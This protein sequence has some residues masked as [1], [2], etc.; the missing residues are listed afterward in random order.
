MA[1]NI[2]QKSIRKYKEDSC[3][4]SLSNITPPTSPKYSLITTT[5]N[6]KGEILGVVELMIIHTCETESPKYLRNTLRA[7]SIPDEQVLQPL[8][9]ST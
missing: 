4:Q 5:K 6:E 9:Y 3:L 2:W 7:W 1:L 8:E